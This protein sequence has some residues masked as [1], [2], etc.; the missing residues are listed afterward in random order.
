LAQVR[1]PL[2]VY[3]AL[4]PE[5]QGPFKAAIEAAVADVEIRWTY[6][7]TGALTE[8]IFAERAHPQADMILALAATSMIAFEQA[9]L[10]LPYR[11]AGVERLRPQFL[12]ETP[13]YTWTGMDAYLGV[14]C[15][16][17]AA[18]PD[19][20]PA[21]VTWR[22]LLAPA[23]KGRISMPDPNAT[24]TGYLLVAGWLQSMGEKD[25]WAFMDRLHENVATYEQTGAAPCNATA[26]GTTA[27]GLTYDMR[28]ALL[29]NQGAPI[30][31]L[32]PLDGVGWEVEA[33]AIMAGSPHA[34]LAKRVADWA[35]SEAANRLYGETFAIVA[36]PNVSNAPPTYPAYAE[37]R[38]I[39][40]DLTWMSTNRPR[41]LAEWTRRYGAKSIPPRF[42]GATTP[43]P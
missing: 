14:V 23:Y 15:F 34:E 35:A 18:A 19:G 3:T 29:K 2:V 26:A 4:E 30:R 17:E 21:P 1:T 5:Q 31:V 33:F 20:L 10:L 39:R 24:G 38:M 7:Q 25:G 6:M 43:Q 16:N 11:P 37:N 13:P 36:H 8:R 22:D 27:V 28:A 42:P 40:N 41:I 9:G 32:V 12:D